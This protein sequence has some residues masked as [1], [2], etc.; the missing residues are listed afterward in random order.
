MCQEPCIL[1]ERGILDLVRFTS[2][3]EFLENHPIPFSLEIPLVLS[4]CLL[5]LLIT[6]MTSHLFIPLDTFKD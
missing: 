3:N 6:M 4:L 2:E 5:V 1:K